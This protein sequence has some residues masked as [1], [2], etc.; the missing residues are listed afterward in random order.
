MALYKSVYY[1]YYYYY[2]FA[3]LLH[4]LRELSSRCSTTETYES[5][6]RRQLRFRRQLSSCANVVGDQSGGGGGCCCRPD[7]RSAR[8]VASQFDCV[9]RT[10]PVVGGGVDQIVSGGGRRASASPAAARKQR[11]RISR[12]ISVRQRARPPALDNLPLRLSSRKSADDAR[13]RRR[14][15]DAL[16][17]AFDRPTRRFVHQWQQACQA[18]GRPD[19]TSVACELFFCKIVIR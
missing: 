9:T 12:R 8:R 18:R 1:Y 2:Y 6:G 17:C 14:C 16:L 7:G 15:E 13:S 5:V 19:R 4:R 10:S 3:H 11:V